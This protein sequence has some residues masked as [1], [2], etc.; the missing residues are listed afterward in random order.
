MQ[1]R[2]QGQVAGVTRTDTALTPGW[3]RKVS[4][5]AHG[6]DVT[7]SFVPP[8][9]VTRTGVWSR[10][11]AA[12]LRSIT[13]PFAASLV[14]YTWVDNAFIESSPG[15]DVSAPPKLNS[16]NGSTNS[17]CRRSTARTAA[18]IRLLN[19]TSNCRSRSGHPLRHEDQ[20]VPGHGSFIAS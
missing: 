8:H 1:P 2:G 6:S 10:T 11:A 16:T 12:T 15:S 4:T 3:F 17:G 5:G 13:D 19:G 9:S 14:A 18:V 20:L 7:S